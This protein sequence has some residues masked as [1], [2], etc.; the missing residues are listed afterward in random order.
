[1]IG[2][3]LGHYKILRKLGVGGMGEVYLA[4]DLKLLSRNR[5]AHGA[6]MVEEIG[7]LLG[8]WMKAQNSG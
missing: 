3:Q 8:G 1:M 6:R 5:Y 4:Q 2:S 7:R